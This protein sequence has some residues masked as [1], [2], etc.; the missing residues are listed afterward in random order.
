MKSWNI[1]AP[2]TL[3]CLIRDRND[4]S[5][6]KDQLWYRIPVDRF[7]LNIK[8]FKNLGFYLPSGYGDESFSVKY[9]GSIT[10][11][12]T[13][14]RKNLFPSEPPNVKSDRKYYKIYIDLLKKLPSPVHSRL[15]RKI[16]FLPTTLRKLKLAGEIN[17]VFHTSPLE[18][19]LWKEFKHQEIVAERQFPIRT[20]Y[21]SYF[22]DFALF[23]KNSYID[24]ECDG[25]TWHISKKG[26]IKDN[27][28]DN[29]LT[30]MGWKILR[31]SSHQLE[32]IKLC[33]RIVRQTIKSSG[34]LL[35]NEVLRKM[36][37]E[38]NH[39]SYYTN[40]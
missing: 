27:K 23:C 1:S 6:L 31:F 7:R 8:N 20:D 28:R 34:G 9:Y 16:V 15:P 32:D 11:I 36:L 40:P 38:E 21:K 4:F 39:L 18:D 22:L 10:R 30:K 33:C 13:V 24:V 29:L 35:E 2:D 17:D 5:I 37:R 12:S 14:T 3:I 25:D 19:R 26:A